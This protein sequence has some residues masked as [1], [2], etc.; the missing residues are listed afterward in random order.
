MSAPVVVIVAERI[1]SGD[2]TLQAMVDAAAEGLPA[3]TRLVVVTP[4]DEERE[5]DVFAVV[6]WSDD[7]HTRATLHTRTRDGRSADR[8]VA[9]AGADPER[10]RGRALGYALVAMIPVELRLGETPPRE[11]PP[12][13]APAREAPPRARADGAD[14]AAA[15]LWL[16]ATLQASWA[17]SGSATV[18]GGGLAARLALRPFAVRGAV[19]LRGGSIAEANASSL[20]VRADLGAA[21]WT[22]V[23]EP[24][25]TV[26][27][28]SGL[29]LFHH[30]LKRTR[31]DGG[32][33]SGTHTLLGTE[34]V[35]EASWAL[36]SRFALLGA[37]GAEVAFGTTRVLIGPEEVTLFPPV[38]PLGE[39]GVR[40]IF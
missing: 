17:F 38:R 34:L 28:R 4:L 25:L 33:A 12:R 6:R 15:Q 7:A 18:A 3:G 1:P 39:L 37:L 40:A 9:F 14:E 5:A 8:V 27:V 35:A 11:A 29:V 20:L 16:D 30:Q 22:V 23:L 2:P 26:G 13:E 36:G 21:F 24:H 19:A 10:E 32:T 31:P